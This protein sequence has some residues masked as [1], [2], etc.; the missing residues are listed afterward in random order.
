MT[1]SSQDP[2]RLNEDSIKL[3]LRKDRISITRKKRD[4]GWLGTRKIV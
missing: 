2:E 3:D 4:S 1:T